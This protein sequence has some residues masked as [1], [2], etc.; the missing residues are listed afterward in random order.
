MLILFFEGIVKCRPNTKS[1]EAIE[2]KVTKQNKN[3]KNLAQNAT[4]DE[5]E[6]NKGHE[7]ING[8]DIMQIKNIQKPRGWGTG[9]C[10]NGGGGG[11]NGGGRGWNG[12]QNNGWQNNG[13]QNN[14]WQIWRGWPQGA[15]TSTKKLNEQSVSLKPKQQPSV[16]ESIAKQKV[17]QQQPAKKTQN[18]HQIEAEN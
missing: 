14:G 10:W 12:W 6:N 1:Q 8:N 7:N 3:E 17:K 18:M 16:K 2:A 5:L 11:W 9:G 13:R 15:V 4:L